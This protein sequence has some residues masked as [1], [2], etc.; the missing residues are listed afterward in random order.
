[1]QRLKFRCLLCP[2]HRDGGI[3]SISH[4][5]DVKNLKSPCLARMSSGYG[6]GD[7]GHNQVSQDT[8]FAL[9]TGGV[10]Q[11]WQFDG[12][13]EEG[14]TES[15][16]IGANVWKG[17]VDGAAQVMGTG[18]AA[19]AVA[20]IRVSGPDAGKTLVELTR[21]KAL[22]RDGYCRIS[23]RVMHK[24]V[25]YH[26]RDGREIDHAAMVVMFPGPK[27]FT[28]EDVVEYHVHGGKAVVH[29]VYDALL[30][31]GSHIRPARRGEFS[32]RAFM[33]GKMD[34]TQV[35]G[36]A[37]LLC[38]ETEE[39]RKLAIAA[40]SGLGSQV[41]ML[42]RRRLISSLAA[43]EA[44]IDF[45]EDDIEPRDV[46]RV[47]QQSR[48][49][50]SELRNDIKRHI[51]TAP[52]SEIVKNGARVVLLGP[53]NV[54]KSSL[55]NALT[56]REAAIVS[57]IS[58]TTRDIIH[59]VVD[60]RGHK[61]MLID[62]AGIRDSNNSIEKEGIDRIKNASR[63]AHIILD[64]KSVDI[65]CESSQ[66]LSAFDR[67]SKDSQSPYIIEV[68][69]KV[70]LQKEDGRSDG[71]DPASLKANVHPVSCHSGQG[72]NELVSHLADII[73]RIVTS[74]ST[75]SIIN[76]NSDIPIES[77][78]FIRSRHLFHLNACISALDTYLT[79]PL[80]LELAAEE[81]R[82]AS[83]SLG[84][85]IGEIGAEDILDTIFKE[86]CIGK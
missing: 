9:S 6:R 20:I 38:S 42:W 32:K 2:R 59:S 54:G 46:E 74:S 55:L 45:G 10:V 80:D 72:I 53:P 83:S 8:I 12:M 73:D 18:F 22:V 31:F 69:N 67:E 86:F 30:S 17:N 51:R 7:G 19:S 57:P 76:K 29:G 3:F 79:A 52:R 62:G 11:N 21:D 56:R 34:L 60:I 65:D 1:M 4:I 26:P 64:V 15:F 5:D 37:D 71:C 50:I 24:R 25:L 48:E 23:A 84:C 13:G 39:Q 16:G 41:C 33:N 27:S 58:G 77:P 28:G 81:L 36:L 47:L 35:E 40:A 43:V 82:L 14:D 68:I 75:Q 61:V 85:I 66:H 78:I 70:D 44:V 63:S 49:S